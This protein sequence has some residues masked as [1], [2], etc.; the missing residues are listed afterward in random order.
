MAHEADRALTAAERQLAGG[1]FKAAID[2]AQVQVRRR[3]FF[4]LQ[5]R[6]ITMAPNGHIW[7]HPKGD[8]WAPCYASAPLGLQ[9]LFI[10]EMT[11]VWQ[12]QSGINLLLRRPPFARYHY[13]LKD[14][15]PLTAYGIEQQAC[16]VADA[17]LARARGRA[18]PALEAL[19]P[20]GA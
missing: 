10:H 15:R 5:P 8:S 19:L 13:R 14:D 9:A 3:K 17:F 4:P 1:V 20:F 6:R 11:H 18:D 7:C 16:I 12:H 2:Y